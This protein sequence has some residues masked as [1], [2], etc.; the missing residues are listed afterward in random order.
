MTDTIALPIEA[1][2]E[3]APDVRTFRFTSSR[4]LMETEVITFNKDDLYAIRMYYTSYSSYVCH[5]WKWSDFL[6]FPEA[7][8]P[9][10]LSHYVEYGSIQQSWVF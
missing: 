6:F 3:P 8:P 2:D 10:V 1:P 5:P 7:W 9:D 4:G